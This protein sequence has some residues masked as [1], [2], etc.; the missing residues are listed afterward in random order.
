MS[1]N[2]QIFILSISIFFMSF[3]A[4]GDEA[5]AWVKKSQSIKGEWLIE[6]RDG[7]DYLVF[8]DD[9]NTRKGPDL[10]LM[11]STLSTTDVNGDNADEGSIIIAP[12][13]S[14]EGGQEY[15][16]PEGYAEYSTL[17]IHCEK[18][19]KLWGA[20]DLKLNEIDTD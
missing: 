1:K 9:F 18:F 17:L 7:Y 19:S 10:K 16:L 2:T 15:K 4:S 13:E 14:H 5:S 20:S 12:L 11:L 6:S 3:N 8:S